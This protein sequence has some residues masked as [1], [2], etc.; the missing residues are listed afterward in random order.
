M[1]WEILE[2]KGQD[3]GKGSMW[4]SL[5]K[6]QESGNINV[7]EF[8]RKKKWQEARPGKGTKPNAHSQC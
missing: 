7:W 1:A 6:A 4:G 8:G 5:R 2:L 3:K